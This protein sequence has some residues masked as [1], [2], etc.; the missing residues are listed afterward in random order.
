MKYFSEYN[1]FKYI[2]KRAFEI[3]F[4][5]GNTLDIRE[6]PLNCDD[7]N[8]FEWILKQRDQL[9]DKL[10]ANC[11]NGTDLWDLGLDYL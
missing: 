10:F 1:N 6:N 7:I 11:T 3:F 9:R 2:E 8:E 5:N 4:K